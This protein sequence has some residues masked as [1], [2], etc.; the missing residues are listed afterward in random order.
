MA[1]AAMIAPPE[2]TLSP[3]WSVDTWVRVLG[4]AASLIA[5]AWVMW[6]TL[7]DRVVQVEVRQARQDE[8]LQS[9]DARTQR[10]EQKVDRL[11]ERG[12]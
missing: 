9:I 6:S 3:T 10:I 7:G 11:I 1:R 4:F 8:R 5:G 12:N 2:Q